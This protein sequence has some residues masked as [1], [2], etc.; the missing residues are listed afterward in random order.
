ML[1]VTA[2][3]ARGS[4]IS[5][6]FRLVLTITSPNRSATRYALARIGCHLASKKLSSQL[7]E[8]ETRYALSA[9]G[10]NDGLWDWDLVTNRDFHF[11]ALVEIHTW[12]LPP[13]KSAAIRMN[14][15]TVCIP[16]I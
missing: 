15:S 8:S 3:I 6:P 11:S 12:D 14:G 16:M 1:M 13:T 10:A 7:R 4:D 5:R 2:R 9:Q